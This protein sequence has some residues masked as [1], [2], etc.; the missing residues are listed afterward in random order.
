[1]SITKKFNFILNKKDK[2]LSE[3]IATT[4]KMHNAPSIVEREQKCRLDDVV[5]ANQKS[6]V[7]GCD[8]RWFECAWEVLRN[9]NVNAY[10]F[11]DTLWKSLKVGRKKNN[12]I[13]LTIIPTK[14]GKTFL[15]NPL[16][17]YVW[18]FHEPG[19]W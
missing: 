9:N 3:L 17:L 1:M 14:C 10:V 2:S 8:G 19:K 11:A 12:I 7:V 15:I 5:E 6:C 18:L 4:W 13:I 16:E